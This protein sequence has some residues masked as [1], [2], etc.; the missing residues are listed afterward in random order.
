MPS[1]NAWSQWHRL[2]ALACEASQRHTPQSL[3][4]LS[5]HPRRGLSL[6]QRLLRLVRAA[7]SGHVSSH[8]GGAPRCESSRA[9]WVGESSTQKWIGEGQARASHLLEGSTRHA[10]SRTSHPFSTRHAFS[11]PSARASHLLEGLAQADAE[12]RLRLRVA[13]QVVLLAR[14]LP[15]R[16]FR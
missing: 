10:F 5:L 11:I 14:P 2:E 16:A 4:G 13:Q 7:R 9:E 3:S 12:L 15:R 8:G 6:H 1:L